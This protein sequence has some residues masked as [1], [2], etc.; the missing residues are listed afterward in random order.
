MSDELEKSLRSALRPVDPGEKFT[1]G[2]LARV[3]EPRAVGSPPGPYTSRPAFRW[4]SATLAIVLTV[5][6][7]TA[8]QWREH[9]IERGLE[10]R[11]QLLQA[12]EVTGENLDT[13]YRMINDQ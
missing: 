6:L 3:A 8:H 12:L 10:A 9:R 7:F 13:A 5:G 4:T 2:V 1:Q 11:R